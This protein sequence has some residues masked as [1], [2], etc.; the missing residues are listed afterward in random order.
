M[1]GLKSLGTSAGLVVLMAWL[2]V[3]SAPASG[4]QLTVPQADLEAAFHCPIDPANAQTTPIMFVTGTGAT[5]E[6]GYLIGQGAF[7][8]SGHPV[9]YVNF[10]DFTTADIQISV[11]YL[12]Y[13]LRKEFQL[14]GRKVAVIGIS[15]GACCR[16]S[17]SSTGPTCARRSATWSLPRG[18]SMAPRSH[19]AARPRLPAR[20]QIGSS[21]AIPI[22]STR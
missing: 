21:C 16:A 1:T 13:G 11:Q 8:A 17:P 2:A 22:S 5:G 4:P 7:E 12:V 9:C 3:P 14:A 6:Q 19:V 18:P 10:P 20:R 15:Q